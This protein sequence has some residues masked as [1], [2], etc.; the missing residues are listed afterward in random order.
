[1]T[2]SAKAAPRSRL[3][4]TDWIAAA[5]R[6]MALGGVGTVRVESLAREL[7]VTK[8]SFYWHFKDRSDLLDRL[9]QSWRR[10]ATLAV[11]DRVNSAYAA[12]RER[13]ADLLRLPYARPGS[14]DGARV[15]L[16]MRIWG[17]TEPRI[18]AV[19]G[20]VDAIRL[21]YIAKLFSA[22][23]G[24]PVQ[25][26]ARAVLAYA[27]IRVAPSLTDEAELPMLTDACVAQLLASTGD[28][29]C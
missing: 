18:A 1:M 20:E 21:S 9:V 11:I 14:R 7:G 13:L 15:E 27:Y 12:P 16:A 10:T 19:L 29:R 3:E 26:R 2:V 8:G 23:G 25:A 5:L 4:A 24:D 17:Q 28:G 6:T 22:A